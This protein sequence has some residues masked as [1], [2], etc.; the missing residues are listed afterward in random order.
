[1]T[2]ILGLNVYH[3]D[4]AAALVVDGELV[5][6]AEEERFTRLKHVAGFPAHAAAWCLAEAGLQPRDL[7][8]VAVGRDPRA[9]L[10]AKV[11]QTLRRLRNPS[12]VAAR[13]QNMAKVRKVQDDLSAA[14]GA[15]GG[16]LRAQFHN[17]EHHQA[18][19][20][21]AFFVSPFEEAAILTLDGFGDFASAMLAAGRATASRSSSAWSSRTRSASST[22][23]SRSG[24][25]SRST[26]TRG[27]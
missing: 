3:G 15:D 8:H 1:M 21:S 18:H 13:L 2:S 25:G 5:A 20:A 24:S 14:L 17:V 23:R 9:N 7:D 22:R 12:Y 26:A 10:G 16:G 11:Q 6:A 4:A 19:V 27:R